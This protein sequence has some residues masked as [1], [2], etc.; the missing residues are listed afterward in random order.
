MTRSRVN[1]GS[2]DSYFPG[3][4][5]MRILRVLV[6]AVALVMQTAPIWAAEQ[7]RGQDQGIQWVT[8][9]DEALARATAEKKPIYLDFF[10]P[11]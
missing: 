9:F 7:V 1:S 2:V 4:Q 3:G 11:N 10:N 8:N 6:V 5:A